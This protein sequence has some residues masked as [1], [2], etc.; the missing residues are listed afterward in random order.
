MRF[1]SWE[2]IGLDFISLICILVLFFER[3]SAIADTVLSVFLCILVYQKQ[4]WGVT[5]STLC[6]S[7][8]LHVGDDGGPYQ[9]ITKLIGEEEFALAA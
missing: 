4:S 1:E 6:R 2:R 7:A 8:R 5:D 3:T 9:S